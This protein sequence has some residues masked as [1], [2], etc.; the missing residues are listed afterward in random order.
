MAQATNDENL[1]VIAYQG[2]RVKVRRRENTSRVYKNTSG[3][4]VII[5]DEDIIVN[6]KVG[7]IPIFML[8]AYIDGST[9]AEEGPGLSKTFEAPYRPG[10]ITQALSTRPGR[11]HL[12]D[13]V[14]LVLTNYLGGI[15]LSIPITPGPIR[16][17]SQP[18][19]G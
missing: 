13:H 10:Q 1:I 2:G 9:V 7:I 19:H 17:R 5:L 18:R 14:P 16:G 12:P 8:P 4:I 3:S 15:I 6:A 11:V